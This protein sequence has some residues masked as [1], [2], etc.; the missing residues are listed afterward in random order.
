MSVPDSRSTPFANRTEPD[1]TVA[2]EVDN[3]SFHY[4]DR[5]ALADV[6]FSVSHGEIFG[7]LGPNGG[8]KTTLFKILSTVTRSQS[9]D[10]HV[11]GHS[12]DTEVETVRR[13]LGIVFQHPSLDAKLSVRENLRYHGML[14]GLS[15]K[16]LTTKADHALEQ[17]RLV[18]RRDDL[19]ETLSGGLKRRVELAKALMTDPEVLIMDEPSTGLDPGARHDMWKYLKERRDDSGTTVLVTT[20]LMEEAELCDRLAVL[21]QG[22]IIALGTPDEL[23][24]RI[25]GDVITIRSKE[26]NAVAE[27]IRSTLHLSPSVVN[28]EVRLEHEDAP[29]AMK[30][31]IEL[32]GDRIGG[33]SLSKPTLEDVFVHETG[34]VFW[35][36]EP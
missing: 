19:V 14:F 1:N 13:R 6:S 24:N 2:V 25:G 29:Q 12:V 27:T 28:N 3:V 31:I 11:L 5:Q 20:H 15:G 26:P 7:F 23:K 16:T 17:T 9:G 33:I 8:G 21:D 10:V 35:A 22:R 18:E 30:N 32:L 4:D 36:D 34:H